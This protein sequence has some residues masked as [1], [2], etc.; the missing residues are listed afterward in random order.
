MRNQP[1]N[2]IFSERDAGGVSLIDPPTALRFHLLLVAFCA[3]SVVVLCRIAW[4]Q[5]QLQDRYLTALNTT[6]TDYEVIPARDGRILSE[7]SAVLATDVDQYSVQ[8][9]YRWLQEPADEAWIARG[10]RKRLSRKERSDADLVNR[11]REELIAA[12][13]RM[14]SHL[15]TV[16]DLSLP[17]FM[18]KQQAIQKQ[19]TRIADSVNRRR[20]MGSTE[21][22]F[23]D[24]ATNTSSDGLLMRMASA[25]R[26]A[27]TTPPGTAIA[28]TIV[29]R[30]EETFH[31]IVRD[32]PFAVAARIHEQSH[33][34]PGIRVV[35][36]NR[37][38]YPL[39]ATASHIVGA[40][41]VVRDDEP[42][43]R[44]PPGIPRHEWT[45][46]TGRFGV[47]R[48]YDHQL[49]GIPGLRRVVRN[50]RM[51]IVESNVERQPISGRDVVLTL[52]VDLQR[53]AEQ[54][55][56][57]TLLDAPA[58]L[59][60]PQENDD[61]SSPQPVPTGGSIVVMDVVSGRLLV[62]ASAPGF[63]LSLFTGSSIAE[64]NAVNADQRHP[65]ISR[66]IAMALP[67]GSVI[68]PVTAI[69]ALESGR[70][71]PDESFDCQG[72][73]TRPDEHRCLIYRLH[74]AG[75]N[76]IT[77]TRAI[78]QSCNVYFF[79]AASKMGFLPLREWCDRFGLGRECGIDL[80][81]EKDGNVPG[82]SGTA[83]EDP[84]R[85]AREAL[86]LAIGQSSLTVTPL[87][88]ARV[89]AAIANGGWLV[90]PHVVSAD[91]TA[92]TTTDID[93]RPR[94]LSR[95]RI[96]GLT[97]GTLAR[98]RE[99][100]KA[101][102]QEPYGTG[103]RTVR[104]EEVAI[105]GKTGTAETGPGKP[106]HAWFAGYVPA[107]EP[108]YAFVVVLEHGGSGSRAAGPVTR[109]LVQKMLDTGLVSGTVPAAGLRKAGRNQ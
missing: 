3:I 45:A 78:A 6:S 69:A 24:T 11:T 87:Q 5:S 30:E 77:L 63:N 51:E 67:P 52:D 31:E 65:F 15:L 64:W 105:A 33:L 101:V 107:D 61:S 103:Y 88:M 16:T 18:E 86:G 7:S 79:S 62:A 44:L 74:G 104:R 76:D 93:D 85:F 4:V 66:V 72:F 75:H 46:R 102:V 97:E 57:E 26:S 32:A 109:E 73:L 9:H 21:S 25:V 13:K 84:R 68:K 12:R 34:L 80:P 43:T 95:R 56:A 48:S 96:S 50:R 1:L 23:D 71:N 108:R 47:E 35:V 99:G 98:V 58:I 41:T 27:L 60:S 17:A 14:W 82:S 42:N 40:R 29:V 55:L 36:G 53:H 92:R 91:G 59:L 94:D 89:M 70:L 19:V 28:A 22:D 10:V 81:F 39:N 100:L 83:A 2:S 20:R 106:D 8:V 54:L 49:Q 37:R 38:T 90:T